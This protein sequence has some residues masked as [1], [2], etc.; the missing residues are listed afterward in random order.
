LPSG[1]VARRSFAAHF[2]LMSS[3]ILLVIQLL[4]KA[5]FAATPSHHV[6][7]EWGHEEWDPVLK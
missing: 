6:F 4:V 5:F 3:M 2:A 7:E 1:E